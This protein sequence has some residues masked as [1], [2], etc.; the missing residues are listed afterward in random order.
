M[1]KEDDDNVY[2]VDHENTAEMVR[3]LNQDRALTKGIGG[4]FPKEFD[5][6]T[7]RSILDLGCGP[8]GWAQEVAFAHPDIEVMGM[9]VSDTMIAYA[10]AQA[11][12][13]HLDN[14]H[15][16]VGDLLNPLD[17]PDASFDLV[18]ARLIAFLPTDA[19]PRLLQECMRV[20]RPGGMCV[21]TEM[22]W[23]SNSPAVE[24]LF[25]TF[26]SALKAA[27]QSFSP[28]GRLIGM[29]PMLGGFLK[30]AGFQNVHL[31]PHLLDISAGTEAA[32]FIYENWKTFYK[33]IQPF[34]VGV[35][36]TTQEKL[37][38]AYDQMLLEVPQET[39]RGL[40]FMVTSSGKKP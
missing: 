5:P 33:V 22:E 12:V 19:W 9:D 31:V 40:I 17:F 32:P 39:F 7:A 8:G 27:G 28:D 15:F 13:Q 10:Q 4:F 6:S 18:N 25:S 37:D 11:K 2:F 1:V 24:Q 29:T 36:V 35:G 20:V 30:D 3:L 23:I 38:Q 34:L 14:L 21:L 26:T 16:C